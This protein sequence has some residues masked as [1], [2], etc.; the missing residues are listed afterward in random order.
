MN[1]LTIITALKKLGFEAGWA[2]SEHGIILWENT[3]PQPTETELIK[4][5]WLK[6]SDEVT[7]VEK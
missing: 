4:A 1:E 7:P 5:G 3:E 2:A 6:L